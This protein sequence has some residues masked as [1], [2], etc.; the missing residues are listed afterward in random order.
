M[1]LSIV[2]PHDLHLIHWPIIRSEEIA[3]LETIHLQ[4]KYTHISH[5]IFQLQNC[6]THTYMTIFLFKFL[7][8]L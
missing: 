3:I 6:N 7:A 4:Y 5:V 2:I 8:I 1:V